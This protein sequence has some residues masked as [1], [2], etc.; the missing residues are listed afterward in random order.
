[1]Y[2][3]II[4]DD[5]IWVPV[6]IKKLIQRSGYPFQVIE[7]VH[8]G[9]AALEKTAALRPDILISDIRMPGL[10]GLELM[11]KVNELGTGTK[12]VLISGYAEFKYAQEAVRLGALDYLL[13]PIEEEAVQ[14]ILQRYINMMASKNREINVEIDGECI[15]PLPEEPRI[16]KV[17]EEINRHYNEEIS[18]G[19]LAV[20]HNLSIGY[21]SSLIKRRLGVSFTEYI[22]AKRIKDAKKLL[23]NEDYS[24]EAVAEMVGYKDYFYF[25]KVFKNNTGMS[26]SKYRKEENC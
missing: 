11:K 8:N 21:L 10:N 16:R 3:V 25:T 26:P 9:I 12:I 24:I 4:A 13:K 1:M 22:T 7:E 18:L 23:L 19:S 5:E 6:G 14:A 17:I 15:E 20:E 2:K